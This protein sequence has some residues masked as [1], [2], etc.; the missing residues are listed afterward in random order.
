MRRP[1]SSSSSSDDEVSPSGVRR[2]AEAGTTAREGRL[3]RYAARVEYDGTDFAGFQAQP[4]R[5][6]VQGELE[7]ALSRLGG[8]ARI[9][10][11]GAG[12]TDAGVH[13]QGQVIAFTWT[14]RLRMDELVT[15]LRAVLPSDVGIGSLWTVSADFRP[16]YAAQRREYRYSIWNGPRSPLRERY[17]LGYRDAL[18]VEAMDRAAQALVGRHDFSAFGG[19]DRQPIRTLHGV[20][21]RRTGPMVTID[22]TGDAFLRQMVRS[23]VAALLRVGRGDV[24]AEDL[25]AA[26]RS[27]GRAFA[28]AIAPPHGL[29]LRR[30][31]LGRRQTGTGRG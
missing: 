17:A 16:R 29:C 25:E 15:A 4:G 19:W 6:T 20:R 21:V 23:I 10:V 12:R 26:L 7:S 8:G 30:V 9:R 14:G 18:D 22:V 5:R 1:S 24:T 28:G 13:A 3:V 2:A 27:P 31:V 11:D